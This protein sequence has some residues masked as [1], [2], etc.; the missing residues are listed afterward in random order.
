[1]SPP[2]NW[3]VIRLLLRGIS[4]R[5]LNNNHR[6]GINTVCVSLLSAPTQNIVAFPVKICTV[7][8]S[9]LDQKSNSP[10]AAPAEGRQRTEA[11]Q[12]MPCRPRSARMPRMVPLTKSQ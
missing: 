1:M 4:E 6:S 3:S 5:H 12:A 7:L 9:A 8:A 2:G 11:S 10:G